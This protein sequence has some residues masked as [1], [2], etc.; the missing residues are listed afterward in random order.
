VRRRNTLA[1]AVALVLAF[2]GACNGRSTDAERGTGGPTET[3]EVLASAS[4]SQ[5]L[6]ELGRRFEAANPGTKVDFSFSSSTE[7]A[8]R[9]EHVPADLF[10]TADE[11]T[12]GPLVAKGLLSDPVVFARN[13]L[14]IAVA[15]GNPKGIR[16]L[17]DLARQDVVVALC[18]AESPCG[19]MASQALA[20]AGVTVRAASN[21]ANT[22]GVVSKLAARQADAGIVFTTNVRDTAGRLQLIDIPAEHNVLRPYPVAKAR[23]A[24]NVALAD[25]FRDFL[26]SD[27]ARPVLEEYGLA[28]P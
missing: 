28:P 11:E 1:A 13:R 16:S 25:A 27:R 10:A 18:A 19:R 9:V 5:V 4:L 26:L 7:L 17:A 14:A 2:A 24:K 21:E 8:E 12:L 15:E 20:R 23:Q 3:V 6:A 22:R